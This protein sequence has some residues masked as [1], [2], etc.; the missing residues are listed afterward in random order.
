M[1]WPKSFDAQHCTR[2]IRYDVWGSLAH[3]VML[4][5]MGLLTEEEL[6]TLKQAFHEILQLEAIGA[7]QHISIEK[8]LIDLT[9]AVGKKVHMARSRN[10]QVLVNLRL[11]GKE[12]LH[13]VVKKLFALCETLLKFASRSLLIPMPGYTQVSLWASAVAEALLDDEQLL[14]AVY[15]LNDQCPLGSGYGLPI[16][17]Q[18]V[19]D[20]LGFAQVQPNVINSR[21]RIE[22][23]ILQAMMQI[24]LDLSKLA[25]DTLLF[26][27]VEYGFFQ[28]PQEICDP[29][30]IVRELVRARTHTMLALQQQMLS[31]DSCLFMEAL[32]LVQDSLSICALVIG[33]LKP[34]VKRLIAADHAYELGQDKREDMCRHARMGD[35]GPTQ[36]RLQAARAIW[37]EHAMT[38]KL[39]IA[40]LIGHSMEEE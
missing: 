40:E 37:Q 28:I 20:L 21:G 35:L 27:T 6:Q 24:M 9:G 12:Q 33:S 8:Y 39:A 16:D 22:A 11:Y 7:F 13:A 1:I 29:S 4:E 23:A 10:D 3:V 31:H 26:T 34:N 19:S 32:D 18:L 15:V 14:R 17:R 2:L 30:G 5:R 38:L 25:Q 36:R